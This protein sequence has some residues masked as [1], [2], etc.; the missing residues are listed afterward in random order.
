MVE[1]TNNISINS[2][3][4]TLKVTKIMNFQVPKSYIWRFYAYLLGNIIWRFLVYSVQVYISIILICDFQWIKQ[5][6]IIKS[7]STGWNKYWIFLKKLNQG[8][9]FYSVVT[10]PMN[11]ATTN[12]LLYNNIMTAWKQLPKNNGGVRILPGKIG[13]RQ[14]SVGSV[15]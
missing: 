9:V 12:K 8:S 1:F 6:C 7:W 14:G 10:D 5:E 11:F 13:V 2:K 3:Y 15:E 4:L